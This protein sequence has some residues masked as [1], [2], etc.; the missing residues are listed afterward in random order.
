MRRMLWISAHRADMFAHVEVRAH[1]QLIRKPV[2]GQFVVSFECAPPPLSCNSPISPA[3]FLCI[4]CVLWAKIF[5]RRQRGPRS[6]GSAASSLCF[7]GHKLDSMP[8]VA[9][10]KAGDA[11]PY[12]T[13]ALSLVFY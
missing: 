7:E 8:V 4:P 10:A 6:R 3:H 5:L 11:S 13:G 12:Q 1:S 9:L 2:V